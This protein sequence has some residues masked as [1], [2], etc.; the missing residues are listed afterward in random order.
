M[1]NLFGRE[2]Q[3]L[4]TKLYI[5]VCYYFHIHKTSD[6]DKDSVMNMH[7]INITNIFLVTCF[8]ICYVM[9]V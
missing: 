3:L 6:D 9:C 8:N 2:I 7:I 4:T 1:Y 5:F